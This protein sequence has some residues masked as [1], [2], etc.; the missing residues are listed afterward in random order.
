MGYEDDRMN[1]KLEYMYNSLDYDHDR[2]KV[3]DKF[4]NEVN[5]RTTLA[6]VGE[7]LDKL[8]VDSKAA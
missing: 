8:V 4:L 2:A 6:D 3:R 7:T 1:E 5:K